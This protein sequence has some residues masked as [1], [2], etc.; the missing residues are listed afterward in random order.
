MAWWL[1]LPQFSR[2]RPHCSTVDQVEIDE[3]HRAMKSVWVA[4]LT[5]SICITPAMA[6]QCYAPDERSQQRG[7]SRAVVTEGGKTIWLAGETGTPGRDFDT[8]V[9][10]AFAGRDKTIKA[11]GGAGPADMGTMTVFI[12]GGRLRDLFIDTP[13][14]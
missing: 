9:K 8:Q 7:Y 3:G 4:A 10:E 14:R 12:N 2:S 6:K 13:Q 5:A 11:T 1:I